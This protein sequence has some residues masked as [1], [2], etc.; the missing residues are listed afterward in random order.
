[1]SP[2]GTSDSTSVQKMVMPGSTGR[3]KLGATA[4]STSPHSS[5]GASVGQPCLRWLQAPA[6]ATEQFPPQQHFTCVCGIK[7]LCVQLGRVPHADDGVRQQP[8]R[9]CRARDHK[10][11]LGRKM[12]NLTPDLRGQA[13]LEKWSTKGPQFCPRVSPEPGE[14][15]RDSRTPLGITASSVQPGGG[16]ARSLL[17]RWAARS[18]GGG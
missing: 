3:A 17:P 14:Q 9:T 18:A 5:A 16:A 13:Q 7:R 10:I 15:V 12:G 8:G 1:M 2:T 4:M 11:S 6:E